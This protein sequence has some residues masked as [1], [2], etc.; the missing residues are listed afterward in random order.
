MPTKES[1]RDALRP[2]DIAWQAY[3]KGA[4]EARRFP[5]AILSAAEL[6]DEGGSKAMNAE[7]VK[8]WKSMRDLGH[9]PCA[10]CHYDAEQIVTQ[11]WD[12]FI[13][14][15]APGMN[16]RVI[17]SG[18]SAHLYRRERD[19]WCMWF[20]AERLRQRLPVATDK[21]RVVMTRLYG[22][23]QQ[24]RDI[25][26]LIGG[27]KCVVDAMVIEKLLVDDAPRFAELHYQQRAEPTKRGLEVRLEEVR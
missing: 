4:H 15:E 5:L 3:Q 27:M 12:L 25:D 26:N 6:L 14:R 7:F 17:N 21:R 11:G 10:M 20:R 2:V 9:G 22:G 18:K 19:A 13:P 1:L 23:R 16:A 24:E 8:W